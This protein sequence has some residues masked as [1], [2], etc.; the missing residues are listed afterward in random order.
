MCVLCGVD[1]VHGISSVEPLGLRRVILV[2]AW[3]PAIAG[4]FIEKCLSMARD[5]GVLVYDLRRVLYLPCAFPRY[6][7]PFKGVGLFFDVV[8]GSLEAR[9]FY[10]CCVLFFLGSIALFVLPSLLDASSS[11]FLRRRVF[12]HWRI[13]RCVTVSPALVL[14]QHGAGV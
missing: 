14:T 12:L 9:P 2:L 6:C 5:I 11:D 1:Y 3:M 4:L 7:V 13:F 8:P 10:V